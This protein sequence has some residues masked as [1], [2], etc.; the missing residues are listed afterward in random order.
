MSR[1]ISILLVLTVVVLAGISVGCGTSSS[2]VSNGP[3]PGQFTTVTP[4]LSSSANGVLSEFDMTISN[5]SLVNSAGKA[6]ILFTGPQSVEFVGLNAG[7]LPLT[8][9]SIPQDVYTSANVGYS[10]SAIGCLFPS[11]S[12]D[13]TAGPAT[14]PG[15]SGNATVKFASPLTVSG[16]AV[17]VALDLA[18]SQSVTLSSCGLN[19]VITYF[20]PVFNLTP[21]AISSQPTDDLNGNETGIEGRIASVDTS[22]NGVT[23]L[24]GNGSY[25]SS[26]GA[27]TPLAIAVN[28]STVYQGVSGISAL[29]ANMFVDLDANVQAD[30]SLL[31]TRFSVADP[32]ALNM[33]SGPLMYASTTEVYVLGREQQGNDVS[34]FPLTDGEDYTVDSSTVFKTSGQF[35][36]VQSLPF[37]ATFNS[38]NAT[39]GQNVAISSQTIPNPACCG[40]PKAVTITLMPQTI[41]GTVAAVSSSGGFTTYTVTL[42]P[43][44]MFP[45]TSLPP[46]TTP[47]SSPSTVIAYVD[48]NTRVL[49]ATPAT[50]SVMR[51]NGLVFNDNGTLRM[52]CA[53]I[54]NGVAE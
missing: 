40:F 15:G 36:N 19:G 22:G 16:G 35:R 31:A 49:G 20:A 25:G 6:V 34:T 41:N 50:G 11:G 53:Q 8:S 27:T 43:Y 37:T 32:T 1:S 54:N 42:A 23:L 2:T 12:P 21:L 4:M 45:V 38:A 46:G 26:P 10:N 33:F 14:F 3:I 17:D 30:G 47:V 48:A 29:S 18:V 9:A 52:D 24:T 13:I 7:S 44:D 28:G 5:I 51:F 39:G